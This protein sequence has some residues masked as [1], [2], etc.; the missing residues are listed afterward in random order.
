MGSNNGRLCD[1]GST[2]QDKSD[3]DKTK[4]AP[5]DYLI[6]GS[7]DEVKNL[8][9]TVKEFHGEGT[10]DRKCVIPFPKDQSI[11]L[12]DG[13]KDTPLTF[14]IVDQSSLVNESV[15]HSSI[16]LD[17]TDRKP[18]FVDGKYF[19]VNGEVRP[20]AGKTSEVTS[21]IVDAA[22]KKRIKIGEVAD[23]GEAEALEAATA[24]KDAWQ[25]GLGEWPQMSIPKRIECIQNL[26]S[27]LKKKRDAIVEVLMWEICKTSADAAK[28]FD[29]TMDYIQDTVV[30]LQQ[31]YDKSKETVTTGG[32]MGNI[33]RGPIGVMVCIGPFNYP[34]NETYC[35]FIPSL[36]MGN[37]VVMKIPRTGG[38]AHLLTIEAF[39]DTLPKG[40]VNF[41]TGS[42]RATLPPI[43]E[44]GMI[45]IF[46]FIGGSRAADSLIKNHPSP[47][48]LR[49]CLGLDAK[50]AG[51]VMPDADLDIAVKECVTGSTSYNGQ[52]CTAL[53]IMF[54]HQSI[55]E[56]F[57][58]KFAAAVE[59]LQAGLPWQSGVSITPLPE[60]NKTTYMHEL[61]EDANAKG[62]LILNSNGGKTNGYLMYPAVVYPVTSTMRLWREE[63]FG[64]VVPIACWSEASEV[65]EWLK[66][67]PYGQQAAVFTKNMEAPDT[68]KVMSC[69]QHCVCR[70]NINTQCSRSP[71]CFPFTGRASSANGTLS[72]EEALKV[73]SVDSVLAGKANDLNAS[74]MGMMR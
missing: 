12:R 10:K 35:Q 25:C 71:D 66:S 31:M 54:V 53:K 22:T 24:A 11:S 1:C 8:S 21:P 47:H 38:L 41:V 6:W 49:V 57:C 64:P 60:N 59:Q 33:G 3:T 32:I 56:Q 14:P 19:F 55:A 29:R 70:I 61:L 20:W 50:N 23:L 28:E 30:A 5:A 74:L 39:K 13:R 63:Q 27:E 73:F 7:G 4:G 2:V 72:I 67:S 46:A 62:A 42:G 52:R 43:M 34:F 65:I 17:T 69:L 37:T 40:V 51:I 9:W 18:P 16:C 48:K 68:V 44:S 26:V 15:E 58:K 45:D 36:M